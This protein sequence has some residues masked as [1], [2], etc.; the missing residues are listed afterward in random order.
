MG[1]LQGKFAWFSST[2]QMGDPTTPPPIT[3]K[4]FMSVQSL[5]MAFGVPFEFRIC[6][7]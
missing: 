4:P 7:F 3:V 1:K 5:L 6:W 2:M